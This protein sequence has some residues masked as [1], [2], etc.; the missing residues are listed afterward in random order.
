M[1]SK[2]II[3]LATLLCACLIVTGCGGSSVTVPATPDG[4][5]NAFFQSMADCKPGVIWAAMPASYQKDVNEIISIFASKM[6][7]E[8]YDKGTAL[9]S[10]VLGILKTKRAF[11]LENP[12]LGMMIQDKEKVEENWDAAVDLL[13]TLINSDLKTLDSLKK[14]DVGRF[15][16]TTGSEM[17]NQ[18]KDI[19]KMMPK[20]DFNKEVLATMKQVKVEV[21]SSTDDTAEVKIILPPETSASTPIP[22]TVKLVK[23]E[24]K[25]IPDE[26]AR[27]WKQNMAEAKSQLEKETGDE[28]AKNKPEILGMLAMV[29]GVL[30]QLEAAPNAEKFNEILMGLMEGF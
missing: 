1:H 5:V 7:A 27:D 12:M 30:D 8:I 16:N 29:D 14:M 13:S 10:K 26:L 28:M 17:M 23:V 24:G 18:M 11:L 19:S 6:D 25:W 21:L 3:P 20:D 9:L 4:T 22:E 2:R 15:L